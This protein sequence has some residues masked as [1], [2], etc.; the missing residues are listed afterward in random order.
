M[1]QC[2][3]CKQES[4]HSKY[5]IPA[6]VHSGEKNRILHIECCSQDNLIEEI[7]QMVEGEK[8]F[9]DDVSELINDFNAQILEKFEKKYGTYD[10]TKWGIQIDK[11][12]QILAMIDQLKNKKI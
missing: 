1:Y 11:F 3:E 5:H 12:V 9:Y 4:N 7:Q 6:V 8:M 10:E 2:D